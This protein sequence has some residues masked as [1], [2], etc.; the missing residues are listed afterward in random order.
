MDDANRTRVQLHQSVATK[1]ADVAL[2]MATL[3]EH[4]LFLKK[5]KSYV[6]LKEQL[7]AVVL[8]LDDLTCKTE[9]RIK[10]YYDIRPQIEKICSELSEHNDIAADTILLCV[11]LLLPFPMYEVSTNFTSFS[12]L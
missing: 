8:V 2:L 7:A 11:F 1:E 4:K 12:L 6:S 9:E 10:Q 5:D 3:G